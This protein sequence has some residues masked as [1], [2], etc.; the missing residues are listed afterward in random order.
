MCASQIMTGYP[1]KQKTRTEN[2]RPLIEWPKKQSKKTNNEP[3]RVIKIKKK[4]PKI[5]TTTNECH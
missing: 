2:R 4:T 5:T 3:K 1:R